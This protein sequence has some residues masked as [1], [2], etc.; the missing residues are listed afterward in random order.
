MML[1]VRFQV[2]AFAWKKWGS[3]EALDVEYARRVAEKKKTKNKKFDQ[4]LKDLRR[5]TRESVWQK[6]KDAEHKHVFSAVKNGEQVCHECGFT[7]EVEE[8]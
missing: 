3:P 2:E 7:I 5:R 4:G 1:Y 6:R 8:F